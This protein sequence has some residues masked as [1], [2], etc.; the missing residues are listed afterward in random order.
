MKIL[1]TG[2]SGF[3][4]SAL[5]RRL[6]HDGHDVILLARAN[7][8]LWR[9]GDEAGDFHVVRPE[10]GAELRSLVAE[11]DPDAVVHT[12]CAYGRRDETLDDI[13]AANVG[14]GLSIL[15]VLEARERPTLFLNTGT[16][17]EPSVNAYSLSKNQFS[18]WGRL[19]AERTAGKV[20][21]INVLLQHMY[22]PHDD[23]TKFTT[24][25][26]RACKRGEAALQ[27]TAGEQ[28]RDFI[29]IDDVTSAY[30]ALLAQA[31]TLPPVLDVEVGTGQAPQVRE[32]VE[33]VKRV[34]GAATELQ[35]GAVPYRANEAMHCQADI[36]L[37]RSLGWSPEFDLEAGLKKTIELEF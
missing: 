2:A 14:L 1:L 27:L 8:R 28:K 4:G 31:A 18:D 5:A 26:V 25:V 34:T 30:A 32:F 10:G 12:A 22:G 37:M 6:R 19:V 17:L 35:F 13:L 15:Q 7:S 29:Y 20:Q 11:I 24:H 3:L 36:A 23:A 16:V 21:F 33:T 9:M